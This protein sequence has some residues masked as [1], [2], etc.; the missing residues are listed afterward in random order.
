MDQPT[1]ISV[2]LKFIEDGYLLIENL[3]GRRNAAAVRSKVL[4]F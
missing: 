2:Q 4:V 3:E 1:E